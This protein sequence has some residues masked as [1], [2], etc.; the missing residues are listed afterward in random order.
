[1][2]RTGPGNTYASCGTSATSRA[3]AAPASP[4]GRTPPTD[5]APPVGA[6]TPASRAASVDFPA[7]L[8]PTTA[9]CS[10]GPNPNSRPSSTGVPAPPCPYPNP[11]TRTSGSCP[12][13][14]PGSAP[15]AASA[16]GSLVVAARRSRTT[17]RLSSQPPTVP[18]NVLTA[19]SS[20]CSR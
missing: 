17:A 15:G 13:A 12:G 10:P 4:S 3:R 19:G 7:P 20:C 14:V 9:T 16:G 2:D 6:S 18:A 5:T 1:M 8:T 11:L